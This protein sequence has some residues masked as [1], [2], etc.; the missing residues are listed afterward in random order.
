MRCFIRTKSSQVLEAKLYVV[1]ILT[2]TVQKRGIVRGGI[3]REKKKREN[4]VGSVVEA[5][6]FSETGGICRSVIFD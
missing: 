5:Y 4:F 3:R 6:T 2:S 1:L